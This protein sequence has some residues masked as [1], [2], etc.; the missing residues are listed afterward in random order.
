LVLLVRPVARVVSRA[1]DTPAYLT[2][3]RGPRTRPVA[4]SLSRLLGPASRLLKRFRVRDRLER[5]YGAI[6]IYR[7]SK[8]ELLN[9]LGLSVVSRLLWVAACYFVGRAFSLSLSLP[10]LLLVAPIVELVRMIPVSISGIG[11]REAA[12]AV[13]LA[14]FGVETSLGLSFGI[15]VYAVFFV[16][17]ILG[18]TLYGIGSLGRARR[19]SPSDTI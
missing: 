19:G 5:I 17:A 9:A 6:V 12:F 18:G 10:V 11:L 1:L 7:D 3:V 16:F 8:A 15:V 14:Q 2:A 13:M 4:A